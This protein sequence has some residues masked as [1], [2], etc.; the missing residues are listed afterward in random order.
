MNGRS[1][2]S[3]LS[4]EIVGKVNGINFVVTVVYMGMNQGACSPYQQWDSQVG[5]FRSLNINGSELKWFGEPSKS[6]EVF[7]KVPKISYPRK[8]SL[9]QA[10]GLTQLEHTT[11]AKHNTST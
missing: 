6:H 4:A 8:R 2:I 11:K 1:G 3:N 10:H 7:F 9:F 5:W